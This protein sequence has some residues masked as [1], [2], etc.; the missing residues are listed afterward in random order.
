MSIDEIKTHI[1][2]L[3]LKREEAELGF[4]EV[5][6]R[7][8]KALDEV[9]EARKVFQLWKDAF[10]QALEDAGLP[11]E[12][13]KEKSIKRPRRGGP[14]IPD[15]AEGAL[16]EFGPLT[17]KELRD[18]LK[19]MGKETT[20]NTVTVSL[21]RH[22]PERFDRNGDGKWYVVGHEESGPEAEGSGAA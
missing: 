5:F 15:L 12:E 16:I 20:V 8:Q 1:N 11:M 2:W 17:S 18:V 9:E 22:R 10:D 7:Y 19:E 3:R 21:N 14:T 13:E 4:D 6:D